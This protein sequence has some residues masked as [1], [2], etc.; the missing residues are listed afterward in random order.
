[1]KVSADV[2]DDVLTKW[3]WEGIEWYAVILG[4]LCMRGDYVGFDTG[5]F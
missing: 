4:W 5:G 2:L 1:M 3:H